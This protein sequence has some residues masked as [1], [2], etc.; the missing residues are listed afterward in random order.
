MPILDLRAKAKQ[1]PAEPGVY[2]MKNHLG[3]ILYVGKAKSLKT[4]VSSYFQSGAQHAP[5]TIKMVE[6]VADFDV[7]VVSTEIE[8]LLLERNLI[9]HHKPMYNVLLTDDKEYPYI[10]VDRQAKWPRFRKV[11]KRAD[12]GAVYLG[13]YGSPGS[14]YRALQVMYKIFPLIRCS[15]HEFKNAKRPCNYYHM[16]RCLAPCTMPVDPEAYK[17]IVDDAIQ[18]LRHDNKRAVSQI[19]KR[20]RVAADQ[21]DFEMAA[22]YR[23]QLEAFATLNREQQVVRQDVE[24]ADIIGVHSSSD[25]AVVAVLTVRG[26][27]LLGQ[28][29]YHLERPLSQ[30]LEEVLTSFVTQYYRDRDVPPIIM[31]SLPLVDTELVT[32]ALSLEKGPFVVP[33]IGAKRRLVDLA[34]KNAQQS[35]D[36]EH[37][38]L[39]Q[40]QTNLELVAK[41]LGQAGPLRRVECVDISNF[42]ETA[43]VA[44][45]VCFVDGR[46]A[47]NLYRKYVIKGLQSRPDDFAAI[48]EVVAR[49]CQRAEADGDAPDLLVVD[50]G[51]GQL[52]EALA[53]RSE[54]SCDFPMVSLAKSRVIK[55]GTSDVAV[56]S[57]ERVFLDVE[58]LPLTLAVGSP[59][60]RLLTQLRDEAHR[61]AISFHRQRRAKVRH[62]SRLE[63]IPGVGPV[64]RKRLLQHFRSLRAIAAAE[65]AALMAVPGVSESLAVRIKAELGEDNPDDGS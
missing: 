27:A 10:R 25:I 24:A 64:L 16:K 54:S 7:I 62:R 50:G 2:L 56:R 49:R 33:K 19:K 20:M 30:P 60:Y 21:E 9:R 51:V 37:F 42:Q 44:A 39:N 11:R 18:F 17:G 14:L 58:Q 26:F 55:E 59:T 4:R 52:R 43:I 35:F 65:L 15:E 40:L 47:K 41:D 29:S 28:Q 13:P 1:A 5:R 23:D 32:K 46:P 45:I 38:R 31:L 36:Q 12:D 8:A 6:K 61:F 22:I 63:E 53:A 57:S 34:I 48:R 3:K